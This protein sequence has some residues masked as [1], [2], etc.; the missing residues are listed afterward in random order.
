[1]TILFIVESPGKIKKISQILG[2]NYIVKASVGHIRDL[3]PNKMSIDIDN[4][5]EPIYII[6][7][8]DVVKN[9]KNA[10]KNVDMVYLA[11]D[12]D[13]EG[14][15][16]AQS[17][18]DV[19]KPKKYKRLR[20][21]AITKTAI[22]DAIKNAD[23]IDKNLVD[24]QKARRVLD[25][26][27]GYLI[28]PILQKQLG[29]KLSAG[30]VQSV[31]AKIVIDKENE[32]E[33]FIDKNSDSSFFKVN[34]LFSG[35]KATL[36]ESSNKKSYLLEKPFKGKIAQLSIVDENEDEPNLNVIIFMKKCLKSEFMIHAV[37]DKI[38][39]KSPTPPFTTST[40]QQ[41]ANRK[42]GMSVDLTMKIAQKL[43]EE[44][45]IT[46][47]RTDSVEIS[48]DGHKEIKKVIEKEYGEE[49]YQK[50]VYKNKSVSAQMAHEAIRPT[51]PDILS[52]EKELDDKYQIKLYKLIWQRTIASQMKPA[53][54]NITTIQISIS[55]FI[56]EKIE[57]FYYFQGQIEKIIFPGFMLV[58][59]ESIDDPEDNSMIMTL[60]K[61]TN[62][63]GK[64]PSI[65]TKLFM[66]EIIAKQEYMKP[67][68]RYSEASLVKKLEEL[69]IGR[70]STFVNTIKTII[71]REYIKIDDVPGIK[72]EI[73]VYTI[74][75]NKS[76]KSKNKKSLMTIFEDKNTI[77]LGKETKKI[78]P[79]NLGIT[80]NN[81]L[82]ENF[83][84]MMDYK[85]TAKIEEELDAI[86]NGSKVWQNVIKKF[87]AKLYPNVEK[88]S[89]NKGI[90]K[91]PERLI[92]IDND[93]VEI[94]AINTKYGPKIKK[95]IGNKTI[96]GDIDKPL[97]IDTI[98]IK[99]AIKIFKYPELLGKYKT[100]E[101]FLKKG[102]FGMFISCGNDNY[103]IGKELPNDFN[104][105]KAIEIIEK[106]NAKK[107]AEFNI[108]NNKKKIRAIVLNGKY[109]PYVQVIEKNKKK[110]Y[111]VPRNMNPKNITEKNII[112]IMSKKISNQKNNKKKYSGSKNNKNNKNTKKY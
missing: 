24:A 27:Y 77:L 25:R 50:N 86:S 92:G 71:M 44:G 67:P 84:E 111:P 56:K 40:L 35:I 69:G 29:G 15:Q 97:T 109:G 76:N 32:I 31:A 18:Y 48:Q 79:T 96:Y 30:R 10:M 98:K 73:T 16:I 5:F 26:L 57:P 1:M 55:K 39:N 108:T 106:N 58:Y 52:L 34:G 28:S 7:K 60:P 78:I 88:L 61:W 80:V 19:L 66:E 62:F 12:S 105:K 110:N 21:N 65:G 72:K 102:K 36:Y 103:S 6:M 91:S 90:F 68:P 81:F 4:Y 51:H 22:T 112:S 63:K 95:M 46:Y 74:K 75:S 14:E 70:P 53:K 41:E 23:K 93:G 3:D 45:Y 47:M 85:F 38:A 64:I 20:F 94:Y 33:N 9:L 83:T 11:A 2:K 101:V 82:V 89:V 37:F 99:D 87:Y 54:I 42:F 49:Y 43:Y 17:L 13:R 59:M 100:N 107:I 8:H 104:I